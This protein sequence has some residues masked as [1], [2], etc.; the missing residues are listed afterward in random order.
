MAIHVNILA[1]LFIGSGIVYAMLGFALLIAP[2]IIRNLPIQPDIPFAML[3]F[4]SS[5]AGLFGFVIILVAAGT[6][7]AGVGLLQYQTWGRT[8][9]LVMSAVNLIKVP[10]GTAL[11][12]YGFWVLLSER[13]REYYENQSSIVEGRAHA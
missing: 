12:I 11:G 2:T 3:R 8:L 5:L 10:F 9:A 7:A 4:I 6:T 13:G 1:W